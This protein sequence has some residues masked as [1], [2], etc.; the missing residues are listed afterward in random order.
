M[1]RALMLMS[2]VM[3]FTGYSDSFAQSAGKRP[4]YF[5]S[6]AEGSA[7]TLKLDSNP[8]LFIE[9][10]GWSQSGLFAY[11]YKYFV[12]DAVGS[13]WSYA[14]AV[15]NTVNDKIVEKDFVE[16]NEEEMSE[17]RKYQQRKSGQYKS[18]WNNLLKKH[19]IDESIDDPISDTFKN[20][21]LQFPVDGFYCWLDHSA[22]RVI[23]SNEEDGFWAIDSVTWMLTV[24]NDDAQKTIA[25][26][27][28]R[29]ETMFPDN[30]YGRKILGC[31]KSPH[32]N[33]IAVVLSEYHWIPFSG[34]YY[35]VGLD[36][37]GC[38]MNVGLGRA[39]AEP[40][41]GETFTGT[42]K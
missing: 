39:N 33:R 26:D 31:F 32:A 25:K 38:N 17:A 40:G 4:Q 16:I 8:Y 3:L 28:R 7:A 1:I 22:K 27:V 14:F 6:P 29:M 24:G 34:G 30:L 15:I 23:T 42:R 2:A 41:G 10:V 5:I 13:Y 37:F 36:V 11:R 12:D 19:K 21:P 20:V 35:R 9:A 18:K